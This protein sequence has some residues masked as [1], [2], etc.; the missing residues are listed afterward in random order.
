MPVDGTYASP[1]MASAFSQRQ[2]PRPLSLCLPLRKRQSGARLAGIGNTFNWLR[3][4]AFFT[5]QANTTMR[6]I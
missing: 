1:E 2:S 4:N 6:K 5:P 3:L